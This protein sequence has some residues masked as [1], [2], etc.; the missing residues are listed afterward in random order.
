MSKINQYHA[1]A[2]LLVLLFLATGL[3]AISQTTEPYWPYQDS[4]S[5]GEIGYIR[6]NIPEV[7]IPPYRGQTYEDLVPD[8]FDIAE[9]ADWAMNVLTCATNKNQDHEQYFSFYLGNPLRMAHNFSDWCTPKYMEALPLVRFVNGSTF[10]SQVD[11][12]WMD[13]ILKSLGPDGLYYFPVQGKPWYGKEL[14]WSKGVARPDGTIFT[15]EKPKEELLQGLDTY[16]KPHAHS[17]VEESGISQFSHPQPCGRIMNTM[18]VYY[19][20]DKNPVWKDAIIKMAERL[21][22]LAIYKEDY[23][24]FPALYFEPNAKYD[25]S[26]PRAAEP[27][28]VSGAEING[29]VLKGLAM[30]YKLF[31]HQPSKTLAGKVAQFM[32]YRNKYY[33]PNGE[34]IS[35]D[36]NHYHSHMMTLFGMLEY[37]TAVN[38]KDLIAFIKQSF[39]W[40]KSPASGASYVGFVPETASYPG[41]I[42]YV[43]EGCCNADIMDVALH[44]SSFGI[45]DYYEDAERWARN[46]FGEI[47]LSPT[48]VADLIRWGK[49]REEKP[50]LYN[51][52]IDRVGERNIGGFAGWPGGNEFLLRDRRQ[53]DNLIMHCCTGNATRSVYYIW[54]HIAEYQN[55]VLK[56]NMLLNRAAPWVDVY[57]YIPYEGQ[58][59]LKMKETCEKV[60]VH[61]PEWIPVKSENIKVQINGKNRDFNWEARYL[62]LGKVEK[63]SKVEIKFPI[64]ERVIV[65]IMGGVLYTLMM[66]GN[67]VV[68]IDPPGKNCPLFNRQH[69]RV[70]YTP[71]RKMNRFVPDEMIAY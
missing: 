14:W 46:Y 19:L 5:Q 37:A 62:N 28:G 49:T 69:F 32:R 29:R 35:P 67:T 57:S 22:E 6:P 71:W 45:G 33:G 61:A 23:A 25:K 10:F 41:F 7:S 34:F 68:S 8:T 38:D 52:T 26:D 42:D 43:G 11:R 66:K 36:H 55:G 27:V 58:V 15:I 17:L 12:V 63:G 51:E 39:E 21:N 65:D 18:I 64:E 2:C 40:A 47:Q 31:G 13:V 60:L 30:C 70:N 56:V 48:K 54:K 1:A 9:R 50:V 3:S 59:D 53:T 24:Y 44:L 16:A 4:E 20:R